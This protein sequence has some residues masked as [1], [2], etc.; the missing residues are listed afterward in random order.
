MRH[1]QDL[2]NVT[3][4]FSWWGDPCFYFETSVNY[5]NQRKDGLVA[6]D[7]ALHSLFAKERPS[8]LLHKQFHYLLQDWDL[9]VLLG[10]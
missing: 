6:P 1:W 3:L 8:P 4:G 9:G 5:W 2:N 7:N 10:G